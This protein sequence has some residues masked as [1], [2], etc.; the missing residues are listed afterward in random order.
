MFEIL[1]GSLICG[2]GLFFYASLCLFVLFS[3]YLLF[4]ASAATL[5]A[6]ERLSKWRMPLVG[7]LLAAVFLTLGFFWKIGP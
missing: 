5:G 7:L 1:L 2:V 6:A 3:A 4:R